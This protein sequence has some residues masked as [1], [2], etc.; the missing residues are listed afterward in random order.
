MEELRKDCDVMTE[1]N[2][3]DLKKVGQGLKRK[4]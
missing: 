4:H 2:F 3:E 1:Y